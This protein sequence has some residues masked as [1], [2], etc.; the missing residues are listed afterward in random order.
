MQNRETRTEKCEMRNENEARKRESCWPFV[1]HLPVVFVIRCS[2]ARS[3]QQPRNEPNPGTR[4][5]YPV[6]ITYGITAPHRLQLQRFQDSAILQAFTIFHR[7]T[8][9]RD[10]RRISGDWNI[11][12]WFITGPS[13][14]E[15]WWTMCVSFVG[16]RYNTDTYIDTTHVC[17]SLAADNKP[18]PGVT[19]NPPQGLRLK[20]VSP[21]A[22]FMPASRTCWKAASS[23][24]SLT[25]CAVSILLL[26][27]SVFYDIFLWFM[28]WFGF[29]IVLSFIA[30]ISF[31]FFR[32]ACDLH[33]HWEGSNS[34]RLAAQICLG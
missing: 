34:Q 1:W 3:P 21:W 32:C 17:A 11:F 12:L 22:L 33:R 25:S 24:D 15:P 10:R 27:V 9:R 19:T 26:L 8:S 13:I 14:I 23:V 16:R 28:N 20:S 30:F 4:F 6:P 2:R 31:I 5:Q 7:V 18:R 29:P